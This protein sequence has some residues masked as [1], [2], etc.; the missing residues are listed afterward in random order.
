ML[1]PHCL[2][3]A[4]PPSEHLFF[5][6]AAI[7]I[8]FLTLGKYLETYA[9]GRT[10]SALVKLMEL[11]P[12]SAVLVRQDEE[13]GQVAN[14]KTLLLRLVSGSLCVCVRVCVCFCVYVC[15][16]ACCLCVCV[17]VS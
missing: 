9:K 1:C 10:S 14:L 11:R 12:D 3:F 17:C 4:S 7:L 6:T 2:L 13:T 15:V 5:E 8:C 16:C